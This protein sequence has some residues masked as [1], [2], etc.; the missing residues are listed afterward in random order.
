M[1]ACGRSVYPPSPELLYG[2][3]N[4]SE[5]DIWV[6]VSKPSETLLPQVKHPGHEER[7]RVP[8][9]VVALGIVSLLNDIGGGCG[10]AP[11]SGIHRNRR[12]RA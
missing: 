1:F 5:R 12:R 6:E 3:F 10:H 11:S 7:I 9:I 8:G 4:R 2:L